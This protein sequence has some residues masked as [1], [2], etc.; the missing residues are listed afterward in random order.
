MTVRGVS[1]PEMSV[2]APVVLPRLGRTNTAG[3]FADVS[4]TMAFLTRSRWDALRAQGYGLPDWIFNDGYTAELRGTVRMDA[5]GA[6]KVLGLKGDPIAWWAANEAAVEDAWSAWLADEAND[7]LGIWSA[8]RFPFA[9]YVLDLTLTAS[10]PYVVLDLEE[11]SLG[12]DA[13]VSR[14][15]YWG[16]GDYLRTAPAGILPFEGRYDHFGLFANLTTTADLWILT[17]IDYCVRAWA[18]TGTVG[19]DDAPVWVWQPTLLDVLVSTPDG[20]SRS[21]L[22]AYREAEY[23]HLTPGSPYYGRLHG[24]EFVPAQWSLDAGEVLRVVPPWGP[25]LLV[26]PPAGSLT[27]G[28]LR[29]VASSP[30]VPSAWDPWTRRMTLVGPLS[31][32]GGADL[33]H[34]WLEFGF[35]PVGPSGSDDR[36]RP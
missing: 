3:G 28:P 13:L 21:E 34:P 26:D 23:V 29:L 31:A 4:L 36:K 17:D 7:R 12:I 33:G 27:W 35:D 25:V 15:M 14:W 2:D 1:M 8:F 6:Q 22:D 20:P 16:T 18:G 10:G 32:G 24:Y 19:A 11:V 9:E 5:L 30:A